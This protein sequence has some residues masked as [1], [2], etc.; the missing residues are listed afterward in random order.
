MNI[1]QFILDEDYEILPF[2]KFPEKLFTITFDGFSP[3]AIDCNDLQFENMC[4][5]AS[6][7]AKSFINLFKETHA[8]TEPE[9][10]FQPNGIAIVKIGIRKKENKP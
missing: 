3:Y 2:D 6:E 7:S 5:L 9:I 10:A 1:S 4:K 8:I